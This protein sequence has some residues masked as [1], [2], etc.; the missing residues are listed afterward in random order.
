[1]PGMSNIEG[2]ST[3]VHRTG[4]Q[5]Q[6]DTGDAVVSQLHHTRIVECSVS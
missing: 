4:E 3:A 1:M 2:G 5:T 6:S